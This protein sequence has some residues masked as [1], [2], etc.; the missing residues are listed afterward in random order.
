MLAGFV[1]SASSF[2]DLQVSES[3]LLTAED[4]EKKMEAHE[5][6]STRPDKANLKS[7]SSGFCG[8]TWICDQQ[9]I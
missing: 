8:E 6:F 4:Q 2:S 7:A 1:S 3:L 5:A 9:S